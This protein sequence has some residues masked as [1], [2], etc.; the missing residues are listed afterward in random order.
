MPYGDVDVAAYGEEF[1]NV[2]TKESRHAAGVVVPMLLDL[3]PSRS[4]LD[5]GCGSGPWVASFLAN[6]VTDVV[7]VD[8]DYVDRSQ[9][10]M[11]SDH[12]HAQDLTSPFDLGRRFDLVLCLEVAEHLPSHNADTLVESL[13]RHA[14]LIIFSAAIPGQGGTNHLNEQW[15]SYW[16]SRFSRV[17]Y[18][19]FDVLR[20]RLWAESRIGF[21]FRQNLLVF[22]FG[23]DANRVRTLPQVNPPLDLVHPEQF[24]NRNSAL[25]H[26]PPIRT[27]LKLLRAGLR[28]KVSRPRNRGMQ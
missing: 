18:D 16:A 14:D 4:V 3:L 11:P 13:T 24:T 20:P 17:G 10:L 8:G 9:L 28:R 19:V 21:W 26:V 2:L 27:S 5:V 1:F 22:A 23:A 12:F 7:G 25:S 6:G 15:P